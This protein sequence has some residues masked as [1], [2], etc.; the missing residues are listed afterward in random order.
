LAQ[1]PDADT[2]R[3]LPRRAPRERDTVRTDA[4]AAAP[5]NADRSARAGA[6]SGRSDGTAAQAAAGGSGQG[7]SG[8]R[9]AARYPQEVNRHLAR[10]PRPDARMRG[11]TVV[12]FTVA[13]GGGLAALGVA[14]SS[15]DPAFDR[16][17][18]SHVQ[19]AVPFPPPPPGAQRQFAVTIRGR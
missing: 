16:L 1:V 8:G 15:G 19:R 18:L 2:P 13:P 3:P 17:A 14:R 9:A 6:P 11:E 5:G 7:A 12:S 10:L 4:P